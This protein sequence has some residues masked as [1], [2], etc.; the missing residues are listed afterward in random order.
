MGNVCFLNEISP[1]WRFSSPPIECVN[2]K[3]YPPP[4]SDRVY[5]ITGVANAEAGRSPGSMVKSR[6]NPTW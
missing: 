1:I 2:L 5:E 4:G 3:M 6:N